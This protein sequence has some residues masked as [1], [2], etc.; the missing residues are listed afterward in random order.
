MTAIAEPLE[1]RLPDRA[2]VEH[3]FVL[4]E[5]DGQREWRNKSGG[6][7][8]VRL[9]DVLGVHE[10]RIRIIRDGKSYGVFQCDRDQAEALRLA[11][12]AARVYGITADDL[13]GA[14]A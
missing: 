8:R 3:R 12:H 1:L 10:A 7:V 6:M 11:Q 2:G 14:P 9:D 5:Q 13:L 4:R